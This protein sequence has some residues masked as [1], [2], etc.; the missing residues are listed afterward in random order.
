MSVLFKVSTL[1]DPSAADKELRIARRGW[2]VMRARPE[3]RQNG[4]VLWA[5][6]LGALGHE[7]TTSIHGRAGR[8]SRTL[9]YCWLASGEVDD[10]VVAG[11]NL[12]PARALVE[13]CTLT[14]SLGVRTWL[15]YDQETCDERE[16]VELGLGL[17]GI[18]L[19]DF[20]ERRRDAGEVQNEAPD[21]PFPAV[22]DV[23]F[24]GFLDTAR[25]VVRAEDFHLVFECYRHGR[26]QMRSRLQTEAV[27]DE[28]LLAQYLHEI[29]AATNDL[30]EIAALVKGAQAAAFL[31]G[32]HARVDINRWAQRGMV[33]GL[34][35]QLDESAW[36]KLARLHLPCEAAACVLST[37]GLSADVVPDVTASQVADDGSTIDWGEEGIVVPMPATRLLVAQH[38]FRGLMGTNGDRFLVRGPK[39]PE[40]TQKWVGRVLRM[41][42][43][44]TGV[45][46]RAWNASRISI[47]RTGWTQRLG[48]SMSRLAE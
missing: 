48:V 11:A 24:L 16:E 9:V 43:L 25:S 39:E 2:A 46:L 27:I 4:L 15:L 7:M 33:A 8:Y 18:A 17:T 3:I 23:H 20:L 13:L 10:L 12:L 1:G 37:L 30:N 6:L 22:P 47:G 5:D 42:T 34:S 29:T 31:E 28:K 21:K 14:S 32:W 35:M 26:E 41:V 40:V 36:A 45:L 19:T 44:D 38:I